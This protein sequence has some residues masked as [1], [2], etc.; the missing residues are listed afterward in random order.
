MCRLRQ[1]FERDGAD[2]G[3]RIDVVGKRFVDSES[4]F[5]ERTTICI[6]YETIEA[7]C[8]GTSRLGANMLHNHPILQLSDIYIVLLEQYF[9]IKPCSFL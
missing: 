3:F 7:K 8:F 2:K 4:A 5:A 9:A 1:Q 6:S